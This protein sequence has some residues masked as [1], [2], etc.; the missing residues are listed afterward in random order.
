MPLR[1]EEVEDPALH[2]QHWTVRDALER[3]EDPWEGAAAR[4]QSLDG[5]LV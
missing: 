3:P 1:W 2:A 4:G 5:I